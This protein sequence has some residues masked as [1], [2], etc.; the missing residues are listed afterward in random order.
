MAEKEV[1]K[2]SAKEEALIAENEALIKEVEKLK[3]EAELAAIFPG[4]DVHYPDPDPGGDLET[5]PEDPG[6]SLPDPGGGSTGRTAAG[7]GPQADAAAERIV[8]RP[9]CAASDRSHRSADGL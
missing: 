1:K 3:A 8:Y 4:A 7:A 6:S 9:G 5:E 2:K